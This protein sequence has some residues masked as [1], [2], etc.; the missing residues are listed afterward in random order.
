MIRRCSPDDK[1]SI[2]AIVNDAAMAYRGRVPDHLLHDPYMPMEELEQE[3][4]TVAFFGYDEGAALVGVM[5][6]EPVRDVT[7]LRH[8]YVLTSHQRRGIGAA[9]LGHVLSLTRT[10]QLLLGTWKDA[11]SVDFYLKHGFRLMPDKDRLLATYWPRVSREQADASVVLG[12]EVLA[13]R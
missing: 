12:I 13:A 3:L 8:A 11:W 5:G 2:Y 10:P 4:R 7:L 9:L 1:P 6:I